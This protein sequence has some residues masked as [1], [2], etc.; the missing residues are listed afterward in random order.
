MYIINE[1]V[2]I[3]FNL[4]LRNISQ[5]VYFPEDAFDSDRGFHVSDFPHV[6]NLMPGVYE[7]FYFEPVAFSFLFFRLVCF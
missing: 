6:V 3:F 7:K 2:G 4:F 1:L 5:F